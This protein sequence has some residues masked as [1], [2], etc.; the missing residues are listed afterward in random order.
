VELRKHPDLRIQHLTIGR[1]GAPLLVIDNVVANAESLVEMAATKM[2]ANPDSYYPG[3][4]AKAPLG[5][6]RYVLEQFNKLFTDVFALGTR[7]LSFTICHFSLVTTPPSQLSHMQCIPHF[8]SLD[9]NELAFVH[10]LFKKDLGGTAFYRHRSTG[11]EVVD[12]ARKEAYFREVTREKL[13]PDKPAQAYIHG[14][15]ALYEQIGRQDAVFNRMLIYR[16]TSLHS[17][18]LGSD[19]VPDH[20]PRTGRLSL[21]GFLQ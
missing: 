3:L 21:N 5:Y 8:D 16:R 14:D 18:D 4:R 20:D 15:T 6:Q 13:G 1:E 17:G 12:A 9:N 7:T 10:Y 11:F 19:F 2:F